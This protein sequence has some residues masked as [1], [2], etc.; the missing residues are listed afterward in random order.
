MDK[1]VTASQPS[2]ILI[3]CMLEESVVS[4]G[5]S[6]LGGVYGRMYTR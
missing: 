1:G 4:Y 3:R 5:R 6:I 2:W